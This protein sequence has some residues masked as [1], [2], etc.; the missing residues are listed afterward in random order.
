MANTLLN[1]TAPHSPAHIFQHQTKINHEHKT[2]GGVG[3]DKDAVPSVR[4]ALQQPVM[5]SETPR[6]PPRITKFPR[7][8][9][10]STTRKLHQVAAWVDEPIILQLQDLARVQHLS[11]SQTIRGLLTDILRQKFHQQQAATL[12]E[13][14]DQAV[15]KANR[16]MATRMA[17]LLIRIAFDV[18]H[19]KVL[20]TNTLGMQEGMTEESLKDIL[21][22]ADKRT[23]ANL[24]R[25]TPQLT[26]L[27]QTVEQWLLQAEGEG[28]G[29]T[30]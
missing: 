29:A 27:M 25:K 12:P 2:H 28:K 19:I 10:H 8:Q 24:T 23:K 7:V 11:M 3:Q 22:T 9:N 15:A 18:G 5:L 26:E 1:N 4:Q 20:A 16:A 14:I 13:L 30:R 17:W 6:T 21:Q